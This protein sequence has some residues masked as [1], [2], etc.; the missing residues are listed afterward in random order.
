MGAYA[1]DT[2]IC[3]YSPIRL[4]IA[5]N[6]KDKMSLVLDVE[7][8]TEKNRPMSSNMHRHSTAGIPRKT[9]KQSAKKHDQ[10][11]KSCCGLSAKQDCQLS[12]GSNS[13]RYN[14]DSFQTMALD[15]SDW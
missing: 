6:I 15:T 14:V 10:L 5:V 1:T 8:K 11:N 2:D 3:E 9:A 4:S 13:D 12:N 7:R